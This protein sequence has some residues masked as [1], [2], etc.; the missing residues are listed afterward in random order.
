[1]KYLFNYLKFNE[2]ITE[3][4]ENLYLRYLRQLDI[5][6]KYFVDN[7][8]VIE[9]ETTKE[10][11]MRNYNNRVYFLKLKLE[12]S[13]RNTNLPYISR[14][15]INIRYGFIKGSESVHVNIGSNDALFSELFLKEFLI[16]EFRSGKKLLQK[17]LQS[18][19]EG[20]LPI[21]KVY[22]EENI[23]DKEYMYINIMEVER[24][25]YSEQ[26][27]DVIPYLLNFG[28]EK[29]IVKWYSNIQNDKL[30]SILKYIKENVHVDNV[31][32]LKDILNRNGIP[33]DSFDTGVDMSEMGF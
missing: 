9:S 33:L 31:N 2:N 27:Y 7:I 13:A 12:D 20:Y 24:F 30:F 22:L 21:F 28:S 4:A 25:K 32:R 8:F 5:Y 17:L 19:N 10:D 11:F 26:W 6:K 14:I 29:E 18:E 23:F 15:N 16:M 1:M 3:D